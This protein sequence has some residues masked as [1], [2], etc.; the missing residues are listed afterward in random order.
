MHSTQPPDAAACKAVLPD[1]SLALMSDG[2]PDSMKKR[3]VLVWPLIAA[4][5]APCV[6]IGEDARVLVLQHAEHGDMPP[7]RR[8]QCY[9]PVPP[10]VPLADPV[11]RAQVLWRLRQQPLDDGHVLPQRGQMQ[12]APTARSAVE[13][14][15]DLEENL[16]RR[17]VAPARSQ[18][19][20]VLFLILLPLSLSEE[21]EVLGLEVIDPLRVLAHNQWLLPVP[22][23]ER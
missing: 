21:L 15:A 23:R 19:D 20:R 22:R 11:A 2:S 7:R 5:C 9:R 10:A 13:V 18:D 4:S 8:E 12:R 17:H 6:D 3:R 16:Q 14:C 1:A